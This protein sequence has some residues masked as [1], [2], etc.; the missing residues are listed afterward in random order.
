MDSVK[1]DECNCKQQII[2]SHTCQ[3]SKAVP[4]ETTATA[5]SYKLDNK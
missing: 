4:Q 1:N 5:A 3:L 2:H